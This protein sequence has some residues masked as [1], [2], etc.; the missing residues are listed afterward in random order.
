[1]LK[2]RFPTHS[3][4]FKALY[5]IRHPFEETQGE[6]DSQSSGQTPTKLHTITFVLTQPFAY[7]DE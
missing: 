6:G 2:L 1:M 7:L 5:G 4:P 3:G